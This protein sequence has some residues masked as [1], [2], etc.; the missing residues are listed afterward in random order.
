[1]SVERVLIED[2]L[3]FIWDCE[4]R[5]VSAGV[6]GLAGVLTI[7]RDEASELLES[8]ESSGFSQLKSG[9]YTL[10]EAGREYA[11]HVVRAHRLFETLL[12]R[13]TGHSELEWHKRADAAEHSLTK[14]ELEHLDRRLGH[15]QYDPHG[16]PIPNAKG[17]IPLILGVPLTEHTPHWRGCISHIEDEPEEL[18]SQIVSLGLAAH[19]Q[20]EY[21]SYENKKLVIVVEGRTL[22]LTRRM[23]KQIHVRELSE[24]EE[25]LCDVFRLSDLSLGEEGTIVGLSPRCRGPERTRLLDLGIVP[26]TTIT[27]ELVSSSG[28]PIAYRI[29]SALIALRNEQADRILIQRCTPLSEVNEGCSNE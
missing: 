22:T 8:L 10:T 16:D 17:Q 13:E 1:M 6:D 23:A 19:M 28:S 15:P 24:G 20:I 12:A 26:G 7:S 9:E 4:D 29:R 25:F 27:P 5:N 2:A 14:E 3:K 21:L 18:Y 11:L